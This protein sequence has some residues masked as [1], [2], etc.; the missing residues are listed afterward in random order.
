MTVMLNRGAS[1]PALTFGLIYHVLKQDTKDDRQ[2][3]YL[4]HNDRGY[5]SWYYATSFVV[6]SRGDQIFKLG[7]EIVC[8]KN[9]IEWDHTTDYI[10]IGNVYKIIIPKTK[11]GYI[12]IINNKKQPW[13]V[14]ENCFKLYKKFK[15]VPKDF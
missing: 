14:K 5:D 12:W 2:L 6:V 10:T 13:F 9:S 8:I 4:I 15:N 7:N 11:D 3:M 1:E